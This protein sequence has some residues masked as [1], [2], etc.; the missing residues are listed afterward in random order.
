MA[1]NKVILTGFMGCG[2]ST[3]GRILA[4][5]RGQ[6]LLDTDYYIEQKQGRSISDIFATGRGGIPGY[7]NRS[8]ARTDPKT[9]AH[10]DCTWRRPSDR[11]KSLWR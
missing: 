1:K 8:F 2:K 5:K 4:E 10:G 3:I 6:E 11:R 9:G 7:G